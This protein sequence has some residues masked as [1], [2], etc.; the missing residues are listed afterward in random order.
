MREVYDGTKTNYINIY[1]FFFAVN[2]PIR[3]HQ[4][5][6]VSLATI[7]L[8]QQQTLLHTTLLTTIQ[9]T[10]RRTTEIINIALKRTEILTA[11]TN[12]NNTVQTMVVTVNGAD[13]IER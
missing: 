1:T 13:I 4:R 11:T 6:L 2:H 12:G 5:K 10:V 9:A 8:P 3:K 7:V